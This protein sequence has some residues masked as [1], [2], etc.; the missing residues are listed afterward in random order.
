MEEK[1]Q[2]NVDELSRVIDKL[3]E[4]GYV[5]DKGMYRLVQKMTRE[6]FDRF[7]LRLYLRGYYDAMGLSV[8]LDDLLD[9]FSEIKGIREKRSA[10]IFEK[11]NE[12]FEM[13][14]IKKK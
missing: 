10:S 2:V 9:S 1:K 5:T 6:N 11:A 7:C 12:K 14:G 4:N 13:K 3:A 8:P